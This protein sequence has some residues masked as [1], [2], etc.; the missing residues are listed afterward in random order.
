MSAIW[1]YLELIIGFVLLIKGAEILIDGAV[2]IARRLNISDLVI[3]MTVVAFGTSAPELFVN[4]T[5]SIRGNSD[6]AIGNIL[7][8]NI[9]NTL[10][11]LGVASVIRPLTVTKGT[12]WREIPFS[13]LAA[14]VFA[15]LANDQFLDQKNASIISRADGLVLLCFFSVF[16][17]YAFTTTNGSES[18]ADQVPST[19]HEP[20]AAIMRLIGGLVGLCLGGRWIVNGAVIIA[21]HIGLSESVVGLSIVAL[22]TSLP[23]LATS[24]MA[25]YK[26]RANIAVGNIVGSNIF[27]IFFVLGV[28]ASI[29]PL[30]FSKEN[31]I[32]VLMTIFTGLLLF[33]FMFSGKKA[34]VD[35]WEGALAVVVYAAYIIY[36]FSS[37]G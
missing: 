23:E 22:G 11:V 1:P 19:T 30:P 36:R 12:V 17:Y 15:F 2:S 28:T 5:A 34:R 14:I 18:I 21:S 32:D 7:G 25:A 29:K 10:L 27:N 20:P 3:G 16:L 13:F 31:N 8:S 24:T 4:I 26:G 9:A 37:P 33:V 6:L 35:R